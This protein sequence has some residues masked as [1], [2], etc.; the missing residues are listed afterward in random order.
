MT[1]AA[2]EEPYRL[3]TVI[4]ALT[5]VSIGLL[6]LIVSLQIEEKEHPII[7]A[8]LREFATIA[9]IGATLHAIYELFQRQDFVRI[10]N[11]KADH[12]VQTLDA[13]RVELLD[14]LQSH[15]EE[16]LSRIDLASQATKMGM[17]EI[18]PDARSYDYSALLDC[19]HVVAVLNDGRTWVSNNAPRLHLRFQSGSKHT[20]IFVIH[21]ESPM[22]TVLA[23]KEGT[24]EE[25]IRMKLVEALRLLATLGGTA[26]NLTIYGHHLFNPHSVFIGDGFAVVTPYFHARMRRRGPAIRYED[27]P[28]DSFY[29]ELRAD[30]EALVLDS[31]VLELPPNTA[32]TPV[33]VLQHLGG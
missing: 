3:K 26:D 27:S 6:A 24:T 30:V 12:V 8:L 14:Q 31:E 18:T 23:K 11:T 28:H 7:K 5:F 16:V 1:P 25:A 17:V 9:V 4:V 32:S 19:T 20:T 2:E 15:G 13:T 22:I 29:R 21:P 10:T 33:P